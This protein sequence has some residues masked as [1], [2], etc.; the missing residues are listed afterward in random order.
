MKQ[1]LERFLRERTQTCSADEASLPRDILEAIKMKFGRVDAT[2][3]ASAGVGKADVRRV[4]EEGR[5]LK[6]FFK[7]AGHPIRLR[8]AS[9][10]PLADW[11]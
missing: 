3:L 9:P 1:T 5:V 6:T 8:P 11:F 10:E 4:Q 2:V 7:R